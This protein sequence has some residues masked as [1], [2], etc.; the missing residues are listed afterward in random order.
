MVRYQ[1]YMICTSPR[2]GSTLLCGLLAATGAS[3]KP[4][5]WFH[6]PSI[7]DWLDKFDLSARRFATQRDVLTA[8]FDAARQ[9]G[10]GNTETFGLRLQRDSFD[11][12]MAQLDV[13]HPGLPTDHARIQTAFG[14]TLFIHLTRENKL[15][16]AISL[17]KAKQTGLWHKAPDGTELERLSP[18]REPVYDRQVIARE[19]AELITLDEAWPAWFAREDIEILRVTYDELAADPSATLAA[20]LDRL[21]LD[22]TLARGVVPPV[23]RLADAINRQWAERFLV[24]S[25]GPSAS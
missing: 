3:G 17:V 6:A 10:T 16:Q 5:S 11:F 25:C 13:L 18:S 20:I 21:G 15:D 22:Q 1:S 2:S 12:F 4:A 24:E 14:S 7:A 19:R 8:I 23:A 9:C